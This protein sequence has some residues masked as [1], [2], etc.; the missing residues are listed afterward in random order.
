VPSMKP[1]TGQFYLLFTRLH[2]TKSQLAVLP[3]AHHA[4]S[5]TL[6]ALSELDKAGSANGR[7]R[8]P[9]E[10]QTVSLCRKPASIRDNLSPPS[11]QRSRLSSHRDGAHNL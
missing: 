11:N 9:P 3:E 10:G 7:A 1:Q 5:W 4:L 6:S 8:E 2:G